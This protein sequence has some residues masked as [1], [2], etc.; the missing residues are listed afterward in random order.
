[1]LQKSSGFHLVVPEEMLLGQQT[2]VALML[3]GL[4]LKAQIKTER[5]ELSNL[6]LV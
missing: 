4:Q 2:R 6:T 1:V 5:Q 3:H